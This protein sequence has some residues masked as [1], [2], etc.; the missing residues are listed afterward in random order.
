MT[1]WS[2]LLQRS[3]DP[4]SAL[5]G[6]RT[7]AL[8][9]LLEWVD[10]PYPMLSRCAAR[11]GTPFKL[12]MTALP[13]ALLPAPRRVDGVLRP[14]MGDF[15]LIM[16]DDPAHL[17][18]IFTANPDTLY[19]GVGNRLLRPVV[20]RH[21]LLLLD[22]A[23][24]LRHRRMLLPPLH[25]DRMLAYGELVA[26]I[27]RRLVAGW[28][29]GETIAAQDTTQEISM[30]VI[31]EAVFGLRGESGRR[32]E[33]AVTRFT[34]A[35]TGAMLFLSP[36]RRDLGRFSPGGRFL[37]ARERTRALIMETIAARRR[38]PEAATREDI[39]SLLLAV[40]D[41]NGE[42]LG[43]DEL[44]D[45]LITLLIA[46]HETTA[47]ALAWALHFIGATA[48]VQERLQQGLVAAGGDL[49]AI[50]HDPYLD[51]VCKESLRL[52]PIVPIVVRVAQVPFELG[53]VT[54]LPGT[55]FAP[56]IYLTHRR[57]DL[58]PEPERFRPERF[59][60]R[61]LGPYE[62]L[63]FGGGV[64]RC[65]GMAFALYE[66]KIVLATICGELE[67]EVPPGPAPRPVRRNVTLGPAGGA[68]IRVRRR[69]AL[70]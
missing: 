40:R 32:F 17:R 18:A 29:V 38:D 5:P 48:G 13:P 7:P 49:N 46:G 43:D 45:E 60:E 51:A 11:Y 69:R 36:L 56:C 25:G 54:Y 33:E 70:R 58:Y 50:A 42:P 6:P 26:A 27:T 21:S 64:R 15:R 3:D 37:E 16:L 22:G 2:R 35:T 14:A 20:G 30:Q 31:I 9:Q 12:D 61:K 68:P 47:S 19:A 53:G 23:R 52:Y 44:H 1:L 59:L 28:R 34:E 57:P 55:A 39:L 10:R 66:M 63:P 41:E 24:H 8:I 4:R 65:I 67:L 62:F